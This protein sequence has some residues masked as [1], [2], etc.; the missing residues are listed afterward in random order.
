VR[1]D[2]PDGI[3]P[4]EPGLGV[5]LGLMTAAPT[6][7]ELAGESAALA[8]FR[9]SRH[10]ADAV[11]GPR[12]PEPR[13]AR[14]RAPEPRA[15][16]PCAA[17]PRTPWLSLRGLRAP[18]ARARRAGLVA[19]FAVAVVGGFAVA[20]Y[21]D[22]LPAPVQDA[23]YRVL[24][25][26]GV[27]DAHHTT[28]APVGSRPTGTHSTPPEPSGPPQ[29]SPRPGS[30]S[31]ISA[32]APVRLSVTVANARIVAGADAV[33]VGQ[34]THQNQA[35][36]GANLSLLERAEGQSAWHPAGTAT[37]GSDGRAAVT[38]S[39][40]IA[41]AVFRLAGPDGALSRPV[42]V[43]VVPTVSAS[44]SSG[45]T[46]QTDVLTVSSPLADP[47]NL[48]VLQIQSGARWLS[49]Q[50]GDLNSGDQISFSVTLRA[51]E[52]V[53]R[54]VL[55]GTAVHGISVSSAVTVPPR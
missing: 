42:L 45:T 29:P 46:G 26:A 35:V 17:R 48:V 44:L 22:V 1:A 53:Y 21:T 40:L 15:A 6:P 18:R 33:F 10:P 52:R 54:V 39:D 24:S 5:L 31:S 20:A 2:L 28:P 36:P 50:A 37:T 32:A 3:E 7:D 55:L 4:S 13:A 14:P 19:A 30:S 8:M 41:N 12:A 43:I 27:P 23:A 51:L 25:I 11:P 34:L 47:G 16:E 49:V 9:D 38:V